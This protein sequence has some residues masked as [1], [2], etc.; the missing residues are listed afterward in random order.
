M[1]SSDTAGSN[2]DPSSRPI[3]ALLI[4]R[5]QAAFTPIHLE[6][7]NESY[8]H[9]VPKGSESHFKLL[10]VSEAFVGKAP[11]A[12]HRMV[13]DAVKGGS[14][15]LPVHALSIAAKAPDQW[16]TGDGMQTTPDC[17]GGSGK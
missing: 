11:L 4:S 1:A 2:S 14:A 8:K 6:L 13:M 10:V 17:K 7:E 5:I 15:D 9:S 12:R 3:E 16:K